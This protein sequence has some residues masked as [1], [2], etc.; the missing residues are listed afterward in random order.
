MHLGSLNGNRPKKWNAWIID[1][2][3]FFL[4]FFSCRKQ[5]PALGQDALYPLLRSW[6]N[7]CLSWFFAGL[8]SI[9][10]MVLP[11]YR[12]GDVL[13]ILPKM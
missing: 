13:V 6:M 9:L 10:S 2:F 11:V 1:Y 12:D 7:S 4:P 8:M 5:N 3:L